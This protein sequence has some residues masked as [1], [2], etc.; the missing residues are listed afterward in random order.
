MK[1]Q[2]KAIDWIPSPKQRQIAELLANPND[3]R[4][5][6]KKV[7]EVGIDYTTLWKWEKKPEFRQYVQKL[8]DEYTD[9]EV[10]NAWRKLIR[11][12][13]KD[14]Q[15]IKLF[16]ELKNMY[17]EKKEISGPDGGPVQFGVVALPEVEENE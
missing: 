7:R 11:R 8:I 9:G 13:E 16:F 14:T 4:P 17:R 2:E 1:E 5:K 10:P 3:T 15:A 12:M 6:T